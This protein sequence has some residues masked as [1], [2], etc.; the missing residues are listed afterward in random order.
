MEELLTSIDRRD[1]ALLVLLVLGWSLCMGSTVLRSARGELAWWPV[2][3]EGALSATEYPVLKGDVGRGTSLESGDRLLAAGDRPLAG[4]SGGYATLALLAEAGSDRALVVRFRRATEAP[5]AVHQERVTLDPWPVPWPA[6]ALSALFALSA[7]AVFARASEVPGVRPAFVAAIALA[8]TESAF[9]G[10]SFAT[11]VAALAVV[12][13]AHGAW[14]PLALW[15][16]LR[17]GRPPGD[18]PPP[19]LRLGVGLFALRGFAATSSGFDW[20]LTADLG[21]AASRWL[22]PL[23]FAALAAAALGALRRATGPQRRTARWAVFAL[24]VVAS[25]V[26]VTAALRLLVSLLVWDPLAPEF[27]W[28]AWLEGV[29]AILALAFP[30]AGLAAA[31]GA[32]AA[33]V[34]RWVSGALSYSVLGLGLLVGLIAVVPGA[35][36][37]AAASLS[38]DPRSSELLLA[39]GLALALVPL[40]Q[41][42]RARFDAWLFPE[43]RALR[44]GVERLLG[45]VDGARDVEDLFA[46]AGAGLCSLLRP[47][48]L[49]AD[50]LVEG[51]DAPAPVFASGE[52]EPGLDTAG[53]RGHRV[54]IR[55]GDR[56][57]GALALGPKQSG[58]RYS[59]TDR[60]LLA[61]VAERL[62]ARWQGFHDARE[63][64]RGRAR[65][66]ELR[67][68]ALLASRENLAKSRFLAAAS[69]DLRQPLHALG[70]FVETLDARVDDPDL[71]PLVSRIRESTHS[72]EEMMSALLD[73]SKLDA[74]GLEP[75][76][77]PVALGPLF[78]RVGAELDSLAQ[79]RG[80]RLRVRPTSLWVRSDP[81]L[82]GRIL[83][84]LVTNALRYTDQGGVLLAA[85]VRGP[86]VAIEVRDSGRG[87]PPEQL[88][89]VFGEFTQLERERTEG[90]PGLG[91]GLS[92][93]QR[94]AR[95]LDHPIDVRSTP[96]RGSLFRVRAPRVEPAAAGPA[97]PTAPVLRDPV[98]EGRRVWVVDDDPLIRE[99]LLEMGTLWG[100]RITPLASL[101]EVRRALAESPSG[102]ELLVTDDRLERESGPEVIELVRRET[103]PTLPVLVIT[104]EASAE[105]LRALRAAG[106]P[107]LQKP[108]G[109]AKLRA[110]LS[111]LLRAATPGARG[112][113][114][115]SKSS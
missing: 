4:R 71:V 88:E 95:L 28:L 50:A 64:A 112:S 104:G 51:G 54:E 75:D 110:T 30:A 42:L 6:L 57:V 76:P 107:L 37:A 44:H 81:L 38:V 8:L 14:G 55:S 46:R 16:L 67:A 41:R 27:W 47:E 92:I 63:I 113:D 83:Q 59:P 94:L 2:S 62:G 103:R 87:I 105:R 101:D 106:H 7:A 19:W 80:L 85:R 13:A 93:V 108:V 96:D 22:D 78:E 99:A 10:G 98:L 86:E 35:A 45:Q 21:Q 1:R 33:E 48:F 17:I 40:D 91:L 114:Q 82:L 102:P 84:N 65:A 20:P 74:G 49:R 60:A 77:G 15:A 58:D 24:A 34:D 3:I 111:Q 11:S 89:A 90:G 61:A 12:G 18:R 97:P 32:R 109:A 115:T 25:P 100:L 56:T 53:E 68:T 36:R 31:L 69:H 70:L 43:R 73:L 72:L 79:A 9:W 39:L 26:V 5:G 66:D 29:G 23:L 52:L